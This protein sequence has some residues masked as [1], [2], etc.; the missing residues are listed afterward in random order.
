MAK[1]SITYLF[2]GDSSNLR[3]AARG[4]DK[5]L[6][7][8]ES[9]FE[10]AARKTASLGDAMLPAT[11]AL[12]GLGLAAISAASDAQQATGA[13]ESVLGSAADV[14][15]DFGETSADAYGISERAANEMGAKLGAT[16]T[17]MEF[18]VDD[19][20]DT[21]VELQQRAADMA[22][23][24][25]GPV[26]DAIDA[27][28]SALRGERDPIERYG[29]SIKQVDVN[30]RIAAMGLDTSTTAAQK[31]AEATATLAIILEST[32][33]TQGQFAREAESVA[34]QQA[35][36]AASAEDLAAQFG[37]TLLPI[38]QDVLGATNDLVGAFTA[39]P[40][41]MQEGIVKAGLFV[42]AMGPVLSVGGRLAGGLKSAYD[43]S[44]SLHEGL[45]ALR[46]LSGKTTPSFGAMAGAVGGVTVA[47]TAA[48][49]IYSSWKREQEESRQ[50]VEELTA[51]LDENTG[52][53]TANADAVLANRILDGDLDKHAA[54]LGVTI[55]QLTAAIKGDSDAL[56]L[57]NGL[58][59]ENTTAVQRAN[60][61]NDANAAVIGDQAAAAVHLNDALQH[62]VPETALAIEAGRRNAEVAAEM[63]NRYVDLAHAIDSGLEP[64]MASLAL[65][66]QDATEATEDQT[67]A[68]EDQTD[69]VE[70]NTSA[71]QDNV[72]TMRS[73]LDPVFA[74]SRASRDYDQA[75]RD[76]S[77]AQADTDTTA[78]EL[79]D[80]ERAVA[81]AA[82]DLK[83]SLV[84]LVDENGNLTVSA[85]EAREELAKLGVPPEVIDRVLEDLGAVVDEAQRLDDLDPT[86]TIGL[87]DEQFLADLQRLN[88]SL[89]AAGTGVTIDPAGNVNLPTQPGPGGGPSGG[90]SPTIPDTVGRSLSP[91]SASG[92]GTGGVTFSPTIEV[93]VQGNGDEQVMR[94]AAAEMQRQLDR[95][96]DDLLAE[97]RL[98][99]GVR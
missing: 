94:V 25:G 81:E 97:V 7:Q 29:V 43:A 36:A 77:A 11:A 58:I 53:W 8:T 41:G 84:D 15:K 73:A 59:D 17:G 62:L 24:F 4:V 68:T 37:E 45:S 95:V 2:L 40:E 98:Q 86:I 83:G 74:V 87:D 33:A 85:S 39:L 34:G 67:E 3:A 26:E 91:F 1:N 22:A 70:D 44:R 63:E 42:A 57:L 38:A 48:V 52:A 66:N 5:A 92:G 75:L 55:G 21:V 90:T 31:Q 93:T 80:A 35:R 23:T 13:I 28:G 65:A 14:V 99:Q 56:A 96:L 89:A 82:V 18:D 49:A 12:G 47:I 51:S 79:A 54:T 6:G 71:V 16:L 78:E 64:G 20:A 60:G 30:A 50:R 27:V 19:A 76:L 46:A 88:N 32:A 72:D 9:R 10:S 69:A 61:A